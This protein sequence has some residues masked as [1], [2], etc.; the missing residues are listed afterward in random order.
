MQKISLAQF[1]AWRETL[2][3]KRY[4]QLVY[5]VSLLTSTGMYSV[6]DACDLA[7]RALTPELDDTREVYLARTPPLAF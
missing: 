3:D 6:P 4:S 2:D 1:T 5:L 7:W